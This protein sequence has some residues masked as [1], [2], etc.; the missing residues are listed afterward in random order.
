MGEG[1][2]ERLRGNGRLKLVHV[3]PHVDQEASGPS[4][5]VPR[6]CES[7]AAR[8]HDV[9]LSCLAARGHIPG[10]RLD[11][12]RE[13]PIVPR[14]A[15]STSHARALQAKAKIVDVVH[16]HSLWSMVNIASGLI[17]PGSRAKLVTS[18]R[19]TLSE[20]ALARRRLLK[21]AL[22]PLQ[23]AALDRANLLHAT[24]EEEHDEIRAVGLAAPVAV[25]PNGVDVPPLRKRS[26]PSV[27]R[28]LLYLGRLHPIKGLD[29][30][31]A[32]WE[33]LQERHPEWNLCIVGR[34][35]PRHEADLKRMS[36]QLSLRRVEFHGPLYGDAK[37]RA[38]LDASLLVLPSWSENF[39]MVVAEALAH[40]CPAVVSRGAP[41]SGLEREGCGWWVARE[42]T[43]LMAGLDTAM[44][45]PRDTLTDMGRR[46]RN[47]MERDYGWEAVARRM[48]RAYAW[49]LGAADR[50]VWVRL[51]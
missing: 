46:G 19:G 24:S 21:R 18:P 26:E 28:T 49:V 10:V 27:R 39:G 17:V 4:Y 15:I 36:A 33:W 42:T 1:A 35:E 12:H 38:Y 44:S 16:N 43:A 8:G 23:R 50:P 25:I 3:V 34:G 7:L 40:G 51:A 41:W 14:F 22:W 13:W 29:H 37:V 6:L 9:E 20:W 45:T 5:S 30:L 32:A 48:E 47:W 31:L 2:C 11:V